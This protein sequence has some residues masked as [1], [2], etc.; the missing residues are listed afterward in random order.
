MHF[1]LNWYI[2]WLIL[3]FAR[4][5]TN[6]FEIGEYHLVVICMTLSNLYLN[7][8]NWG[9]K[10]KIEFQKWRKHFLSKLVSIW[11][12]FYVPFG[13]FTYRKMYLGSEETDM[14]YTANSIKRFLLNMLTSEKENLAGSHLFATSYHLCHVWF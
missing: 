11:E 9:D 4:K 13:C 14:A 2:W 8:T 10:M 6:P 12:T 7:K 3:D 1:P 5:S